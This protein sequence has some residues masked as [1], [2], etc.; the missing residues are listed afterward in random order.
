[1][2]KSRNDPSGWTVKSSKVV[3]LKRKGS[4][5]SHYLFLRCTQISFA[6]TRLTHW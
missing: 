5:K 2:H 4:A 1:M 3:R 6:C